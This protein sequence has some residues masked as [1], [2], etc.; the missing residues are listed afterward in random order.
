MITLTELYAN[1]GLAFS[2]GLAI[3][4]IYLFITELF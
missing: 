1:F 3:S 4:F 2:A